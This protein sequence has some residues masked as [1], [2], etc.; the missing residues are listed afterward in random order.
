MHLKRISGG[1]VFLWNW[2]S[3]RVPLQSLIY[4]NHIPLAK[5]QPAQMLNNGTTFP[6][7]VIFNYFSEFDG[8][9]VFLCKA[10]NIYIYREREINHTSN[11]AKPCPNTE[12]WQH[13]RYSGNILLFYAIHNVSKILLNVNLCFILQSSLFSIVSNKFSAF[14]LLGWNLNLKKSVD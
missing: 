10:K 11:I 5:T 6:F 13:I 14:R 8:Y 1:F 7:M 12:Q 2:R 3:S 9:H 4:R